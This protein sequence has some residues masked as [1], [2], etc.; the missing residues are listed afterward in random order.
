MLPTLGSDKAP[1]ICFQVFCSISK[2]C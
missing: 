1:G 2:A